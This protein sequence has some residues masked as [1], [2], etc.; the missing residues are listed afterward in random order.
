MFLIPERVPVKIT[1]SGCDQIGGRSSTKELLN[2]IAF[3]N[4]HGS[5]P[6]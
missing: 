5:I 4:F 3:R 2:P 1:L 6:L